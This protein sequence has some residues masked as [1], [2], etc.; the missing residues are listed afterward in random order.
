MRYRMLLLH[1][2]RS[3]FMKYSKCDELGIHGYDYG[4]GTSL[5]INHK[6]QKT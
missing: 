3:L 5:F 2:V 4:D 6:R 1:A